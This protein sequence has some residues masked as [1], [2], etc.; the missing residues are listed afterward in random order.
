M[1]MGVF[2]CAPAPVVHWRA[3]ETSWSHL[4]LLLA[5]A[6]YGL[7]LFWLINLAHQ[8]GLMAVPGM[9]RSLGADAAIYGGG[10]VGLA[11]GFMLIAVYL[12]QR[13]KSPQ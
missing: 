9:L 5:I 2:L 4:S 3:C 13:P 6:F 1:S 12:L 11:S 8:G 10:L 7:L